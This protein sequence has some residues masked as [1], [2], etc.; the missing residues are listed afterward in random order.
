MSQQVEQVSKWI[1]AGLWGVLTR[2][3]R[4]PDHPPAL[5]S[6][7]GSPVDSFKPAIGF[8]NY[9]RFQFWVGLLVID[10]AI[11]VAWIAV[12]IAE[13]AWGLIL[14]APA[15]FLAIVPD[16]VVYLAIHLRYD[17]TWYVLSDRSLRIR[18]GIWII[19]ETT[20]TFEN[21]Q[22]V[23]VH[24]GPLQR[25]FGIA[26]V[27]IETAGGGGQPQGQGSSWQASHCGLIEGVADAHRIREL[28][29]SRLGRSRSAGLGDEEL[30]GRHCGWTAE[31]VAT[32]REIRDLIA[33]AA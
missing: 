14:L 1:Y 11:L 33:A 4:V 28:I 8:L 7:P 24:Q 17:T 30:G 23:K 13:P 31:Q 26:N 16:I 27:S 15:L 9:L 29:M 19:H 32:L 2:W 5:P 18:R 21:I 10:G 22:N 3:F 6:S 12:T 25:W 20:I